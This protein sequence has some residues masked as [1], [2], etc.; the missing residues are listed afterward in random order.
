MPDGLR[1]Y[2]IGDVHGSAD[3]LAQLLLVIDTDSA[4]YPATQVVEVLLGDYIDRGPQSQQVLDLLIARSQRRRM[5][6]LKGNHE[7]CITDFLRDPAMLEHWKELGG[8]ETLSS[9]GLKPSIRPDRRE[10]AELAIALRRVLPDTHRYFLSRLTKSFDCGDY[11][12]VHAGV[13]PGIPLSQQKEEDLLWIRGEFL[14]YKKGFGKII[15]HGHT[16]VAE[17]DIHPNRINIDTGAYA[18][19]NLTCLV[20]QGEEMRFI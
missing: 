10:Q 15:I 14:D 17:P 1:V 20:L 12:F 3:L 2:A 11:F 8:L 16:P 18:T 9:Y 7:N 13:R 4:T 5:V 6:F 19:G